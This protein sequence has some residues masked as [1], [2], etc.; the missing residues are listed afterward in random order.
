MFHESRPGLRALAMAVCLA[1][2]IPAQAMTVSPPA[3][4]TITFET[5]ASG[6][7]L[8]APVLFSNPYRRGGRG[9][10]GALPLTDLYAPLGVVWAG[11]GAILREPSKFGV[12]GC[13]APELPRL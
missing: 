9:D 6:A 13:S 5:D 2:A 10:P 1:W 11:N 7:A 12:T 8:D 3:N 4:T